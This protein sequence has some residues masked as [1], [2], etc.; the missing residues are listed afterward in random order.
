MGNA[1]KYVLTRIRPLKFQPNQTLCINLIQMKIMRQIKCVENEKT[2]FS[3]LIVKIW[4]FVKEI[5][6]AWKSKFQ[7][8]L[9]LRS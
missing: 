9:P 8:P 4:L 5:A 6:L 7:T 2:R 1:K 3:L